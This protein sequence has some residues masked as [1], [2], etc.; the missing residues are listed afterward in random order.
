MRTADGRSHAIRNVIWDVDGTLFD[1]YPAIAR[2]FRAALND[3]AADAPLERIA[4]L[5]RESLGHC[6]T[7]LAEEH[8]LD[9]AALEDGFSR[10]YASTSP[11]EQPPFPGAR[12]VCEFVRRAGGQNVIV[13]H[14][15]PQ[16]TAELLAASG[17]T[18]LFTGCITAADGFPKKPDPAAFEAIIERC[19]LDRDH[20][21]AI[22][23]REI[24][25]SA[26]RAAGVVTCR[27]GVDPTCSAADLVIEALDGL[28]R[29]LRASNGKPEAS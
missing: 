12:Q 2:A 25:V 15:G 17:L 7:A 24:D 28:L 19:G 29:L 21:L 10:H 5:A 6:A 27:F 4:A 18:P 22:G 8:D 16:G 14:R 11:G 9:R 1:T 13:T 23:D 3:L 26:G 20:T